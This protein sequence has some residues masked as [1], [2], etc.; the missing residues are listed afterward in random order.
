IEV[1]VALG[2]VA[3]ALAAGIRATGALAVQAERRS[4]V[5]LAQYCADNALIDLRLQGSLPGLGERRLVCEQAGQL[6]EVEQTVLVTRDPRFRQVRLR[7]LQDGHVAAQ[8]AAA[9]GAW[10]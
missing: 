7:V 9:L 3:V 6:F 2:I 8:L 4:A 1:L 10:P 5:L